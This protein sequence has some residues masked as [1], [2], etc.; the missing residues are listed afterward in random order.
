[1]K[2]LIM[3]IGLP[4][5]GK[6]TWAKQQ[7]HP[8]VNPD[9]IRLALH[10]ERFIGKS[11]PMVW[12]MAKYMVKSLFLAGHDTV[13]LD[14]TNTTKQ[15]RDEWI[16]KQWVRKFEFIKTLSHVCL[17]RATEENDDHIIPIIIKMAE[18]FEPYEWIE[19]DME[20]EK[21]LEEKENGL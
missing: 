20:W 21:G 8:I 1:M 16:D 19:E 11:E 17:D 14:A 2:T 3:T 10:G 4:R 13:I 7:G 9:A 6:S 15:R 18:Q 12:V 5:S